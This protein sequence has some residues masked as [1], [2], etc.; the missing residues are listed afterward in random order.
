MERKHQTAQWRSSP[1]GVSF[2]FF[3]QKYPSK[4]PCHGPPRPMI[5]HN[6]PLQVNFLKGFDVLYCGAQD[7]KEAQ[8]RK[9]KLKKGI[10]A[11]RPERLYV[12]LCRFQ[13]KII[14]MNQLVNLT[15]GEQIGTGT[16]WLIRIGPVSD[17]FQTS[18]MSNCHSPCH[19]P[20]SPPCTVQMSYVSCQICG[21]MSDA[22]SP[23]YP[24]AQCHFTDA[25]GPTVLTEI[26]EN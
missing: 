12:N 10:F 7:E 3:V 6:I 1:C 22:Q 9:V 26:H 20:S 5:Q 14:K 24:K 19:S 21:V 13:T 2:I 4:I 16:G 23:S 8:L 18:V 11:Y 17:R 25:Q 15:V